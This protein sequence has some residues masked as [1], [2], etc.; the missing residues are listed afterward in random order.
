MANSTNQ[1]LWG[2]LLSS[3]AIYLGVAFAVA[4]SQTPREDAD[5]MGFALLG[6]TFTT[7][8][9]SVIIRSKMLVEPIRSGEIDPRSAEGM[10]RAFVP[11]MLC[12]VLSEAI[13]IFGLVL[14]LLAGDPLYAVPFVAVGAALMLYHRP[15]ARALEPPRSGALRGLDSTP[16]T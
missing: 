12:L 9:A 10:Q 11:F 3:L 2:A 4:P 1:I 14:S 8:F 15:T 6:M 5:M 16:I 13:G 7:A